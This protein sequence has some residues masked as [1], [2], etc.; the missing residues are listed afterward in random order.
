MTVPP[1]W[2]ADVRPP[3]SPDWER[4]AVAWL[5]DLCPPDYR[6]YPVLVRRPVALAWVAV[7]HVEA[8]H[9]GARRALAGV[10]T[11]LSDAVEPQALA[12][13]VEALET[14]VARLL[15]TSRAVGLVEEA[16]RGRRHV[17]RL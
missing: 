13:L 11:A 14:E 7:R 1:G 10:R 2:P 8:A 9:E 4:S 17:P 6:G 15:G 5:L 12:A 16:L 3:G